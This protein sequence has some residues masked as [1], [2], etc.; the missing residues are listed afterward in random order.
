MNNPYRALAC[1]VVLLA[2]ELGGAVL[3]LWA[4]A[5][6]AVVTL[7]SAAAPVRRQGNVDDGRERGTFPTAKTGGRPEHWMSQRQRWSLPMTLGCTGSGG[8]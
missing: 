6:L 4:T 2:V 8:G 5:F 3:S 7:S 1:I